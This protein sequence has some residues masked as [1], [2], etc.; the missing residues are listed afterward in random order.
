MKRLHALFLCDQGNQPAKNRCDRDGRKV[1]GDFD[2]C[3]A[4]QI[5]ADGNNDEGTGTGHFCNGRL[6]EDRRQKAG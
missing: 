3:D 6:C 5:G 1:V 4:D 2:L